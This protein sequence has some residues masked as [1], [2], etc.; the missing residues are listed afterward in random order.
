MLRRRDPLAN[1]EPLIGRVYSYAAYRLGAGPDAEDATGETLERALRYRS[2]YD[3]GAGSPQ[4]WLLGIA[5]RVVSEYE[6]RN[7][8]RPSSLDGESVERPGGDDPAAITLERLA[9]RAALETLTQEERD[10]LA[11][12]YGADLRAEDI[13]AVLHARTNAVEVALHR[14]LAKLRV[15]MSDGAESADAAGQPSPSEPS[16]RSS[17]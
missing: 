11:L 16:A 6:A 7:R 1:P 17:A 15:R 13:G 8:H 3:S 2:T 10:L 12:R 9:L 14:V 4:A 5:R